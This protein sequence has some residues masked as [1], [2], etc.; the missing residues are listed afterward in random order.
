VLDHVHLS[1]REEEVL[2]HLA[3]GLTYSQIG[4]RMGITAS[5]VDTYLRRI[6]AKTGT[7]SGAELI[8]LWLRVE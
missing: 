1:L 5:T 3:Q 4:R 2:A 7:H 6:R 8:R